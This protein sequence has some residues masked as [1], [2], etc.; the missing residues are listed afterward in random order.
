MNEK[1]RY[2]LSKYLEN[3]KRQYSIQSNSLKQ[4]HEYADRRLK[5][6]SHKNGSDYYAVMT[7]G[8]NRYRYLGTG[9]NDEVQRIK[10][11]HFL[12]LS[13]AELRAE[14]AAITALLKKDFCSTYEKVNLKLTKAYR[15]SSLFSDQST[16]HKASAWKTEMEHYKSSFDPF[17]PNELIHKT[18]D[19][20]LVRSKGE[21]LI[22]NYLLSLNITF[23]YELPL[24]INTSPGRGLLLPDFTILSE[25]DYQS[26]IYIE[27]QGM[28]SISSYRDKFQ[29][30]VYK[31]W[32]NNIIPQR[33]VFFTFDLPNG[34][35]DDG[36]IKDII[37][38]HLRPH[39]SPS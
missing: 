15:D 19:G 27:H 5:I 36:P 6:I 11:A 30:S 33:D 9:S 25:L 38:S 22:Y 4:L 24:R 28:M 39:N 37:A 7:P 1:L 2:D 21:A 29:E 20:T 32:S 3:L 8:D 31:Y 13:T 10:E 17:K 14:I 12:K 26:V 35:F 23:V 34:G 16:T 18:H